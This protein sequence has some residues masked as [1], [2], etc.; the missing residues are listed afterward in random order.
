MNFKVFLLIFAFT[1]IFIKIS[2]DIY[3][4]FPYIRKIQ[5]LIFVNCLTPNSPKVTQPKMEGRN[6]FMSAVLLSLVAFAAAAHQCGH[7]AGGRTCPNNLCCSEHGYCG[8][9]AEYCSHNCQSNCHSGGGGG[10]GGGGLAL[11]T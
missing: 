3:R 11:V 6:I 5:V 8:T 4:Y 2:I 10:G 1:D 9:T 7:Q